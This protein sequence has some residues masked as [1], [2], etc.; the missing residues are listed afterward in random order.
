MF[1]KKLIAMSCVG[2]FAAGTA[3]AAAPFSSAIVAG[4][5]TISDDDAEVVLKY[6]DDGLGG[7]FY[8]AFNPL[9]DKIQKNDILVGI[10]GITSFPTG[11]LGTSAALYNQITGVYAVQATSELPLGIGIPCGSALLTTCT[12]YEFGAATLASATDPLNGAI[13]LLNA[14]YG[15]TVG[16]FANTTA[17]SFASIQ[18]DSP[19]DFIRSPT[20]F[21]TAY[22]SAADGVQRFVWDIDAANSDY[23]VTTA[24]SD[25]LQ[26]G[27][28]PFG[29]NAGSFGGQGTISY[30]DV[31]GW[32]FA[33]TVALTG[34]IRAGDGEPFRIWTDS[35]YELN[36]KPLPEPATV[37][38][39][40][41]G[42]LGLGASSRV[43][44]NRAA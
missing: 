41:L 20:D 1:A 27:L 36:A 10:V 30:Q 28:V 7:Y 31:P 12:S 44:K 21:N 16:A 29:A 19:D 3:L 42:L 37:V 4:A 6:V 24:P 39:L 38:L 25:V 32:E 11:A 26:L 40:G 15:T 2:L 9:T 14:N 5:N 33:P 43:R 8:R 22:G 35:T 18:E 23:F 34:N 13:A 17:S